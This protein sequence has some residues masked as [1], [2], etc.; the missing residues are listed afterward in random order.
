MAL[1]DYSSLKPRTLADM[2]ADSTSSDDSDR[3]VTFRNFTP[4]LVTAIDGAPQWW[5][6]MTDLAQH[7]GWSVF[8]LQWHA[9]MAAALFGRD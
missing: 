9:V 2:C 6:N 7:M 8:T 1:Y 4:A 5:W 3:C